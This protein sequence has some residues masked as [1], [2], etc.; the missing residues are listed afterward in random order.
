MTVGCRKD[1]DLLIFNGS[2]YTVNNHSDVV[3]AMVILDG[4]VI[5]TGREDVLRE[6]YKADREIDLKGKPVF[7][8]FIDPHCHFYQLWANPSTG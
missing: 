4:Q 5:A 6:K 8:G 1:A 2:I 7:P 3:S